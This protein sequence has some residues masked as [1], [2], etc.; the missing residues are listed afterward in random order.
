MTILESITAIKDHLS[1]V[2]V[3]GQDSVGHMAAAFGLLDAI[4][5]A[6]RTA[7]AADQAQPPAA[8]EESEE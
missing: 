7:Q 8:P 1:R 6:M 4:T 5:D 2:S 3:A